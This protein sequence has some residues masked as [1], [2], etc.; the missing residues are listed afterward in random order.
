MSGLGLCTYLFL[1]RQY[2]IHGYGGE[3]QSF[4]FFLSFGGMCEGKKKLF[5]VLGS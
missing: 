5:L 3:I 2:G 4:F 1:V